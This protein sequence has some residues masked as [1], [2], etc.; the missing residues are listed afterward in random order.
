MQFSNGTMASQCADTLRKD[1]S[2]EYAQPDT[3]LTT[4]EFG[5]SS[6]VTASSD[7]DYTWG[8]KYVYADTYSKYLEANQ[9]FNLM[10][11]AVIDTGADLDHPF[12][13]NRILSSGYNFIGFNS[14]P[15]DD[16]GHGTHVA[17]I[18]A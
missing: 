16:N 4:Q 13:K 17:G 7:S 9:F 2:V 14:K 10:T 11:V 5:K 15:E 8:E 18:I 3:L 12:L 6:V 1:S